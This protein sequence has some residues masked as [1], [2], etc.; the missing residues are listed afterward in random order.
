MD[1]ATH[2]LGAKLAARVWT[3]PAYKERAL[4]NGTAAAQEIGITRYDRDP[5]IV[6]ANT[7]Q[8]HDLIVCTLCSCCP[9]R[10]AGPF[11]AGRG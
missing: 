2:A 5:L 9:D 11:S 10:H 8:V 4:A 1:A 6:M 3:N 7:P